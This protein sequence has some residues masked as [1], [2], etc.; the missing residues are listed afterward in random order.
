MSQRDTAPHNFLSS[1][2]GHSPAI[3]VMSIHPF[4]LLHF[5]KTPRFHSSDFSRYEPVSRNSE[6]SKII[7]FL[8]VLHPAIKT[9]DFD[10]IMEEFKNRLFYELVFPY[11][12]NHY[13]VKTIMKY[14]DLTLHDWSPILKTACFVGD[15]KLVLEYFHRVQNIIDDFQSSYLNTLT[16]AIS[17]H[18]VSIIEGMLGKIIEYEIDPKDVLQVV[19]ENAVRYRN[20][21]LLNLVFTWENRFKVRVDLSMKLLFLWKTKAFRRR[22]KRKI[23]MRN[24][25]KFVSFFADGLFLK[26]TSK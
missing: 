21:E 7:H 23:W 8:D 12:S 16:Q 17:Y 25:S 1:H 22:L 6:A 24:G 20:L 18:N 9:H 26:A 4:K 19:L 13:T 3:S 5:L 2:Y 14:T 15:L 11:V 10:P